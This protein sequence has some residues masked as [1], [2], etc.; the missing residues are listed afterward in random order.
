MADSCM[1]CCED[2]TIPTTGTKKTAASK[3]IVA[4]STARFPIECPI[5]NQTCCD[6]CVRDNMQHAQDTLG[7]ALEG[8]MF[9]PGCLFGDCRKEWPPHF[10]LKALGGNTLGKYG[11]ECVTKIVEFSRAK[12]EITIRN[13]EQ[14]EIRNN[15]Q[16][17]EDAGKLNTELRELRTNPAHPTPF[18]IR[19]QRAE[20]FVREKNE[21]PLP[22]WIV[23]D[24][25]VVKNSAV[26][27]IHSDIT[28]KLAELGGD[29]LRRISVGEFYTT[30]EI[31]YSLKSYRRVIAYL[32]NPVVAAV[33]M[34]EAPPPALVPPAAPATL[35]ALPAAEDEFDFDPVPI[36][37]IKTNTFPCPDTM[38]SGR[39]PSFEG[40]VVSK[41]EKFFGC[42]MCGKVVCRE[43]ESITSTP[44]HD[45]DLRILKDLKHI[46]STT[47]KCPS[48]EASLFK[49]DGCN[50][51]ICGNCCS[52]ID[53]ATGNL[54][55]TTKGNLTY[56][57]HL[58]EKNKINLASR[59]TKNADFLMTAAPTTYERIPI[60]TEF[61]VITNLQLNPLNVNFLFGEG[62]PERFQAA[63][64]RLLTLRNSVR[65]WEAYNRATPTPS[66]SLVFLKFKKFIELYDFILAEMFSTQYFEMLERIH[67]LL[68]S[69]RTFS[70]YVSAFNLQLF[71]T[72]IE[73]TERV[74]H[75]M[76]VAHVLKLITLEQLTQI[77]KSIEVLRMIMIVF[78][79][80][81][82]EYFERTL[83][84]LENVYERL[85][86][87]RTALAETALAG[88]ESVQIKTERF[89][90]ASPLFAE[91]QEIDLPLAEADFAGIAGELE[92]KIKH[93]RNLILSLALPGCVMFRL[94]GDVALTAEELCFAVQEYLFYFARATPIQTIPRDIS[95]L[96]FPKIIF[97][98]QNFFTS[99]LFERWITFESDSFKLNSSVL[100]ILQKV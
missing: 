58:A 26:L 9:T 51:V 28:R 17:I 4:R 100:G 56:H 8:S 34:P 60:I 35:P 46:R 71:H 69:D 98:R 1:I 49:I 57:L 89:L 12:L 97:Q 40:T 7:S 39:I 84:V 61:P 2:F 99:D 82:I 73:R 5:C 76:R 6:I 64:E 18:R 91:F 70:K 47:K 74:L 87:I 83:T 94:S 36:V 23:S 62:L 44:T 78:G 65:N 37:L 72:Y 63:H 45:C 75:W 67:R 59:Q 29:I 50:H 14:F 96:L 27:H 16:I 20:E 41:R 53:Y 66:Q 48:C 86:L 68:P 54:I 22:E 21:E 10:V 77:G 93:E 13:R 43:C 11:V 55:K 24:A 85:N 38:C 79:R 25:E 80:D 90:R 52:V 81:L 32:K 33:L 30:G 42:V 31:P 3:K 19:I 15:F 88:P 95:T 92:Q